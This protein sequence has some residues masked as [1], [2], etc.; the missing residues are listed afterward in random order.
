M[1]RVFDILAA[2]AAFAILTV[3]IFLVAVAV[4]LTSSGPVLYWSDRVGRR[5]RIFRMP[6]FRSMRTDTPAVATHLLAD[7]GQWLTP[8]GSFL[9]KT[10]LDELP[11]LWSILKGDMSFVGPRPALF[12]QGDLIALRT[13][14]GVD[15]LV[16]G[17][18]GWAQVNGRDELPIPE[19][20]RLDVEYMERRSMCF[21]LRILWITAMK[22]LKRDGVTH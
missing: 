22:V 17:L 20:V 7:P 3:P 6:K 12:N 15:A 2:L 1:K 14:A 18:T 13:A 9:R 16:P 8:I 21:D 4:K 19:K 11:Q 5:N 10:S